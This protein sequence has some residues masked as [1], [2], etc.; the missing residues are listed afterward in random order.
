MKELS[1][2]IEEMNK[3]CKGTLSIT[4]HST[5]WQLDS[6]GCGT[7]FEQAYIYAETIVKVI[8]KAWAIYNERRP[9]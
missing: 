5:G 9:L 1:E 7:M 3:A 8:E 6:Y 4:H 2:K